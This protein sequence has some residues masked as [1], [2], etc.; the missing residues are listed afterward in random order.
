MCLIEINLAVLNDLQKI[1]KEFEPVSLDEISDVELM[2]RIDRK[3]WFNQS[4]LNDFL[5]QALPYY[6]ILEINGQ[7]LMEYRTRYFDTEGD[8]MYKMHHN[9][10][11]PRHK[12]RLR[13]YISTD[14]GFLEVKLKTNKK[15]TVKS[16]IEN[17]FEKQVFSFDDKKFIASKTPFSAEAIHPVIFNNFHRITLINK[18]KLDR[19][20]FDISPRF[21]NDKN[22]IHLENLVIFELKKGHSLKSSPIVSIARGLKIRQ[23][24]MSK[25]CT[26]RALLE[27]ELK[28]NSFKPRLRYLHKHIKQQQP[29]ES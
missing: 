23:R 17:E 10:R 15:L 14:S 2:S 28:Q 27:P 18:D 5:L 22:E 20:T 12:I 3:Y 8:E 13:K 19:C 7:R 1:L 4:I 11:L 9:R 29:W 16:R 6:H 25:Y 26:G 21:W 24:G